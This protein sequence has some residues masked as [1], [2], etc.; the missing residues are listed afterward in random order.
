M[1]ENSFETRE[2]GLEQL[3]VKYHPRKDPGDLKSLQESI[4]QVGQ[5][6]PL[7]V[8]ETD[9]NRYTIIDGCRRYKA[10][11][12]F[13]WKSVTCLVKPNMTEAQ[14][15][16]RSY[17]INTERNSL[18]HIEI[19]QHLR[20]MQDRF[21]YSL[22]DLETM[23]YGS[24]SLIS[25]KIQLLELPADV[26]ARIKKGELAMA[27][28]K[29]LLR[30]GTAKEQEKMAKRVVDHGWNAKRACTVIDK[31]LKKG[32]QP[33]LE[34]VKIPVQEIPGV[35][36]K[37]SKD[38]CE[39][40]DRSVHFIVTSPNYYVGME[41]EKGFS[42]A[43]HWEKTHAVMNECGRV[44]VPGG[45]MAINVGDIHNF[46]GAKGKNDFTQIELVGHRYQTMLRKHKTYL[47]D[48]IVWVKGTHAYGR[49]VSKAWSDKMLHTGYRIII[50][51]DP[52]YIFR[53]KGDREV[54]SEE[55]ALKS[56][57][58]KEEWKQ[59]AS[60]VWLIDR[61]RKM[62]GHPSVF[63]DELVRRLICM[64]SYVGDTVLDPFLGSGTTVKVARELGRVG[65]GYERELQYKSVIMKKLGIPVDAEQPETMAK[66]AERM[67]KDDSSESEKKT[68][69]EVKVASFGRTDGVDY[70]NVDVVPDAQESIDAGL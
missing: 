52:V 63:P 1:K 12:E 61:V 5:Q 2:I 8:Y 49:D 38:M 32:K 46:K 10:I 3:E 62:E 23:G 53:K 22:R 17:V 68:Q 4:R 51:Y 25:Q 14:A 6:N 11:K 19:A 16:H 58:T 39:Q 29:E 40:P 47:T 48:K 18:S 33:L 69:R 37:D 64:F 45:I 20:A 43:E 28:G 34:R 15:A 66:Y 36:F 55:I 59:W 56:R 24:P 35:R 42:Y 44:L 54:P 50:N 9:E 7:M 57:I 26:Q 13:G 60:G 67:L 21:G 41:Y 30:L 70:S 27:H 65:I 31:Y